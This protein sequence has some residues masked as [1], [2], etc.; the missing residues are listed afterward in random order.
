M[1][2]VWLL[3]YQLSYVNKSSVVQ[4]GYSMKINM[5]CYICTI[6]HLAWILR[7]LGSTC[8]CAAFHVAVWWS[9]ICGRQ[10]TPIPLFSFSWIKTFRYRGRITCLL[11]SPD[12]TQGPCPITNTFWGHGTMMWSLSHEHTWVTPSQTFS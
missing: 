7:P 10:L 9:C 5:C 1:T 11:D 8:Y 4:R 6:I 12:C 2:K 3:A